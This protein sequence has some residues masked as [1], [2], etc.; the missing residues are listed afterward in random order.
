MKLNADVTSQQN[1]MPSCQALTAI[2]NKTIHTTVQVCIM[3]STFYFVWI[4][5]NILLNS[6]FILSTT[7]IHILIM[8]AGS[9][10]SLLDKKPAKKCCALNEGKFDKTGARSEHTPQ[11]SLMCLVVNHDVSVRSHEVTDTF[12]LS[13]DTLY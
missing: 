3:L 9:R 7:T 11:K 8:K 4:W 13:A 1:C 10:G 6:V 5:F 2:A 12:S